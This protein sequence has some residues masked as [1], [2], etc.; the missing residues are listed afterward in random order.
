MAIKR[1]CVYCAS[2]RSCDAVYHDAATRLGRELALAGV[3]IVYGGGAVGSMG[4]LADGAL[5][6]GGRVVGVLPRFMYDLEWGHPR[7]SELI[8]VNDLHERKRLMI[9]EVD[10]VVALPGSCGTFEELFEA[11][12]WK[13][14]GLFDGPIVLVN[15]RDYFKPCIELLESSIKERFM[16]ERHRAMWSVVDEPEQ[17]LEAIRTAPPWSRDNR[18]FAVS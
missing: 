6:A 7:L 16:N 17:V 3:T 15:T 1:V 12:S 18:R 2:S 14:L 10:A 11:M 5:A 13:R 4:H 8:V 9:E